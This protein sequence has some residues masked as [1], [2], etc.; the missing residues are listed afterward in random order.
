VQ[1]CRAEEP[2]LGQTEPFLAV[3]CMDLRLIDPASHPGAGR[4]AL[5]MFG[6]Y[7]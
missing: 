4:A 6:G 3:D 7:D 2:H 5:F 1:S